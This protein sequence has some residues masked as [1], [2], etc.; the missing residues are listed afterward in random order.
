[1][2]KANIAD[3][4]LT[5]R[6]QY[7]DDG[8]VYTIFA[9]DSIM[10]YTTVIWKG[11]VPD[12]VIGSGYS[13]AQNDSDK[14]DFETNYKD[15]SNNSLRVADVRDARVIRYFGNKTTTASSEVL[16]GSTY[17]EQASQAQRSLVSSSAQDKNSP[18]GSGARIVRIEYL[19][20][21]YDFFT[22]DVALNGTSSVNT[23]ATDIRFIQSM[24]VIAG[25]VAAGTITLKS[26]T[27][28][29]GSDVCVISSSTE[30]AF[31]CHYYCPNGKRSWILG[32]G[33]TTDDETSMKLKSQTRIN[34]LLVDTN[35]D[36]EKLFLGN[37]TPPTR[38]NFERTFIGGTEVSAKTYT[39]VTTQPNQTTSTTTRSWLYILEEP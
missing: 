16:V 33:T 13:Q 32:W 15:G 5:A 11:A 27:G 7:E 1:V 17:T 6:M 2:F 23:V 22:E 30:S 26:S 19:N 29:G 12:S 14:S 36:L 25:T 38:L 20:S 18:P 34:D 24:Y 35:F 37:P 4:S 31:L 28:G 10:V 8:T 21:N 39:R 9:F 3:K